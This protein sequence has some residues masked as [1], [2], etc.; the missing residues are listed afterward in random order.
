MLT[1]GFG[2]FVASGCPWEILI[3]PLIQNLHCQIPK[4]AIAGNCAEIQ[5]PCHPEAT[6]DPDPQFPD[7]TKD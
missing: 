3:L 5:F 2:S 1:I 4:P 6:K 7:L